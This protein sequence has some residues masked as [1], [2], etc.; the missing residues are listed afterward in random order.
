VAGCYER[1]NELSSYIKGGE[2]LDR[3]SDLLASQ[4]LCSVELCQVI[5]H[6]NLP[7][8]LRV[9]RLVVRYVINLTHPLRYCEMR[10]AR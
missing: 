8:L 1:G 6:P 5:A 7:T 4:G 10:A 9:T 2:F 3:L